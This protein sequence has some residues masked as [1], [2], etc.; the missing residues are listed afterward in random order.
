MISLLQYKKAV[1]TVKN[2]ETQQLENGSIANTLEFKLEEHFRSNAVRA[3]YNC[4]SATYGEPL[5]PLSLE[6][7]IKLDLKILRRYR[8]F[9]EKA[10]AKLIE[11]IQNNQY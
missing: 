6:Q 11:L 3:I 7:L 2:Y 8:G 4:Y 1:A 10:E 9:G 5:G